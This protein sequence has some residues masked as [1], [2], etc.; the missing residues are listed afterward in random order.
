MRDILISWAF[1][2]LV[3][4]IILYGAAAFVFWQGNPG[5]WPEQGRMVVAIVSLGLIGC[6]T[7]LAL[8]NA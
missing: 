7:A 4:L 3:G 5:D 2:V 1:V 8:R 6:S